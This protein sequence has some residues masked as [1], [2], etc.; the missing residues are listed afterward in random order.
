[1]GEF[2]GEETPFCPHKRAIQSTLFEIKFSLEFQFKK[3]HMPYAGKGSILCPS[4]VSSPCRDITAVFSRKIGPSTSRCQN[5]ENRFE[6]LFVI[7]KGTAS[8]GLT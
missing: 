1:M 3:K 8:G 7:G 4:L 6:S 5:E 2:D